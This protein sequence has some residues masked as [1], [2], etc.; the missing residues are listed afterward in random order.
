MVEDSSIVSKALA[1]QKTPLH[2]RIGSIRWMSIFGGRWGEND[3]VRL[4]TPI[5]AAFHN[6]HE[7]KYNLSTKS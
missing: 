2:V 3:L 6:Y 7:M 1:P 5:L 4:L